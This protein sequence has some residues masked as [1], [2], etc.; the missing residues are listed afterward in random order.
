M[1]T[2]IDAKERG[3]LGD[4]VIDEGRMLKIIFENILMRMWTGFFWFREVDCREH[5]NEYSGSL[6]G[7]EFL[8]W[9]RYCCLYSMDLISAG[10]Y[11]ICCRE[12][13]IWVNTFLMYFP[14]G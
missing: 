2:Q 7:G 9:L 13:L 8:D 5:G 11:T 6:K 4:T 3:L 1:L 12:N 14:R 10:V